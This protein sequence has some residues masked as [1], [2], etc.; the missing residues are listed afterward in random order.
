[1]VVCHRVPCDMHIIMIYTCVNFIST[2]K[3]NSP[4]FVLLPHKVD[5]QTLDDKI[6]ER[7]PKVVYKKTFFFFLKRRTCVCVCSKD[8]HT[9]ICNRTTRYGKNLIII[10]KKKV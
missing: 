6:Q 7:F 9:C 10:I 3:F 1:M 2:K 8:G 4:R 5:T